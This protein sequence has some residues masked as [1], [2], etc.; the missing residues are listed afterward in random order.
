MNEKKKEKKKKKR[1]MCEPSS[2]S[3]SHQKFLRK[4][5]LEVSIPSEKKTQFSAKNEQHTPRERE[6]DEQREENQC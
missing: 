6:R 4:E 5:D 3:S 1:R 2:S